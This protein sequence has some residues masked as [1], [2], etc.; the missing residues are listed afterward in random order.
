MSGGTRIIAFGAGSNDAATDEFLL[1]QELEPDRATGADAGSAKVADWDDEPADE[2]RGLHTGWVPPALAGLAAAGWTAFYGWANWSSLSAGMSPAAWSAAA[3]AWAT[4]ILLIGLVWLLALRHSRREAGRFGDVARL[5]SEQSQLLESRLITVNRE[6]SLAR[7][8]IAAQSRDLD[9]LGRI[10]V[11][12]LSV[13]ADR[14][15]GLIHE[16]GTRLDAIGS[17]SEAALDNMERLRGQLPVIASSAKDVTNNIA[18]AGRAAL[19]QVEQMAESYARIDA[20]GQTSETRIE[21][22]SARVTATGEEIARRSAELDESM[23]R[24]TAGLAEMGEALRNR[25]SR[26]EDEALAAMRARAAALSEELEAARQTLESREGEALVS[27]RARISALHD[28]SAAVSRA[29]RDGESRA[30][31]A[32]HETV[33]TLTNRLHDLDADIAARHAAQDERTRAI[34]ASTRDIITMLADLEVRFDAIAASTLQAGDRLTSDAQR[35]T[36]NLS[37]SREE[38]LAVGTQLEMLTDGSVRL[39]ELIR[40]SAQHSREDLPAALSAGEVCLAR[41]EQRIDGVQGSIGEVHGR[42]EA[43]AGLLAQSRERLGQL[44]GDVETMHARLV[45][46]GSGHAGLLEKLH[47]SLSELDA[48]SAALSARASGTLSSAIVELSNTARKAVSD[49]ADSGAPIIAELARQL[50]EQSAA[51]IDKAV[52][53][54]AAEAAGKLEQA[55]THA[56]GV[57]REAAIQLRDQLGKVNELAGNLERRVAQA[58]ERAEEQVD[59]DFARRAALITESLNSNAIDIAKALSTDVTDTSWAAYLR[60]DRGIFTRRAVSLL[61]GSEARAISQIY[62]SD[63]DFRDHVSRYIHDFEAILRQ[64]LSTRDGH[65]LGVTLLSSDMGKLYV[66]LA[67]GIERLRT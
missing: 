4:P 28:E 24:Q 55:A 39:L 38:F 25:I 18:H 23:R 63:R 20:I 37:H 40:A 54:S 8:F 52:R 33:E 48:E 12:R 30:G 7:E 59:N 45:Q 51:A 1:T 32:W 3:A 2:P 11:E 66:A 64:V 47:R 29:L 44:V 41:L 35:L 53:E 57:G 43:L 21:A 15:Q 10:A 27:L 42:G 16:N 31:A 13:H 6:L 65:A 46:T 58:R 56:A 5:L 49:L 14:L 19:A 22:L 26:E 50:G 60:G 17:V 61:D 67:Q 36:A 62:E 9:A 34:A